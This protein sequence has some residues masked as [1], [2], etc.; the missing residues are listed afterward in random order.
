MSSNIKPIHRKPHLES[1]D[2]SLDTLHPV[3]RQIFLARGIKNTSQLNTDFSALHPY[4]SLSGIDAATELLLDAIQNNRR[5]L[6]VGDFDV[7]GATATTLAVTALKLFGAQYV[8]FRVPNRFTDG[9]GL[10]AELIDAV[11]E[12][13]PY[14]I[15]TVDNGINQLAGVA[16]ARQHGIRVL[17]TDHH[18][19]GEALPDADVIVNPNLQNDNFPSK[20]LCGVGVI[21][22]VMLAL[23]SKLREHHWFE[24]S[25]IPEPNM[26]QFLDLVALGTVADVVK[27]DHNNRILVHHGLARIRKQHCRVGILELLK[28]AKKEPRNLV[29]SDLSFAVAPRLNAAGRLE[30]M[31]VGIQCLL[32]DDPSAA[33]NL[34]T[35]L[36]TLNTDRM[37]IEKEMHL[38]AH[39]ALQDIRLDHTQH[40]FG[41]CL[42]DPHWHQGVIGI[43]AARLK[44]RYY[45]PVIIFANQNEQEIKGSA[46]SIRELHMRDLLARIDTNHPNLIKKFGGHAMAAGLSLDKSNFA[47][48]QKIF[49]HELVQWFG[50][51]L[52]FAVIES[53]GALAEA[54]LTMPFAQMLENHGPWGSGFPE[55]EFDGIFDIIDQRLVGQKHLKLILKSRDARFHLDAIAFNVDISVWPNTRV[56]TLHA[57]YHLCINEY[58]G[59][60][61]LQLKI[62]QLEPL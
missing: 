56:R 58:Q 31:S 9:Y 8:N 25:A 37:L 43:I 60:R 23:R 1:W 33:K 48:F 35:K 10:T 7:D 39:D 16:H 57:A 17:I 29:A 26:A 21:F 18:L 32:T 55:P 61:T 5:I 51:K 12:W 46:R 59:V 2:S 49:S 44:E 54:E 50:T 22:Y 19:P 45:E 62:N 40:S 24:H 14:L 28:V 30:D 20:H 36:E 34:A 3:L 11:L 38:S 6:I 15:I 13:Q 27:L 4:Q 41:I 53:D 47:Q 52:P 42:Y